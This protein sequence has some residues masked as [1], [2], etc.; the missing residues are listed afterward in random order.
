MASRPFAS[1]RTVLGAL[2]AV[3]Y[4]GVAGL[5]LMGCWRCASAGR[6]AGAGVDL[7]TGGRNPLYL[8]FYLGLVPEAA[9]VEAVFGL[10]WRWAARGGRWSRRCALAC[11]LVPPFVCAWPIVDFVVVVPLGFARVAHRIEAGADRLIPAITRY[12]LDHGRPPAGLR[13]LVPRYVSAVP[14]TGVK[15]HSAFVYRLPTDEL[16]W[17]VGGG[18]TGP[19]LIA[20]CVQDGRVTEA[21]LGWERFVVP[22]EHLPAPRSFDA[23]V[24]RRERSARLGMVAGLVHSGRL[25]GLTRAELEELL[26]T[27]DGA[28]LMFSGRWRL[29]VEAPA[30]NGC[31]LT[32]IPGRRPPHPWGYGHDRWNCET[33][34]TSREAELVEREE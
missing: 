10:A 33:R 20:R 27:P 34:D 21:E 18:Q 26:G 25:L 29:A 11:M 17:L 16:V 3:L 2:V 30:W 13:E 1:G 4:L 8:A 31:V 14:Q 32:F 24:W 5:L 23:A 28:Q 22:S 15:D 7:P 19:W 6:A 9:L 12:D